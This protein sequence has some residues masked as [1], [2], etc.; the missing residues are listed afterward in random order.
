MRKAVER[1]TCKS[2]QN[3][4]CLLDADLRQNAVSALY[5]IQ[6][7]PSLLQPARQLWHSPQQQQQHNSSEQTLSAPIPQHSPPQQ[8]KG[9]PEA[10]YSTVLPPLPESQV[11]TLRQQARLHSLHLSE[12][13]EEEEETVT[14]QNKSVDRKEEGRDNIQMPAELRVRR[15]QSMSF[16]FHGST[17]SIL[18]SN[19]LVCLITSAILRGG[20]SRL[21]GKGANARKRGG[22]GGGQ[23]VT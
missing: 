1:P 7:C 17:L 20:P 22:G 21:A 9:K 16:I 10:D 3:S 12:D 8:T 11:S 15:C 19:G 2:F 4:T 23:L 13:A 6:P 5:P 18:L 14:D